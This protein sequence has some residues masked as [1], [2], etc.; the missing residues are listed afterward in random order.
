M[1]RQF[2]KR[3]AEM[4]RNEGDTTFFTVDIGMW[5]IR[6]ILRDFPD[7]ATNVGIYEDGMFGFAAG[8][9]LRGLVPTIFGIQPYLIERTLEQIKLDFAYQKIGV[10][11]VGTGAAV[12]YPKYGYSHYCAEDVGVIK[13]VPGVEFVAPGTAKQFIQLFNQAYRNGHPTFFRVSDHPNTVY[14]FDVEFGKANVIKTGTKATVIAVSVMLDEVME[15][16]ADKD[17]TVLYYTTLEPFDK[18]TLAE[19]CP[20]GNVLICEP[21][22]V[23]SL[24]YDV[25]DALPDRAVKVKHVGF[26]REIFRNYGT[27]DEKMEYYGLTSENIRHILHTLID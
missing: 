25:I 14:D 6:D 11:V 5:A 4:I 9:S 26:P 21:E 16:C 3:V 8:M 7:R 19:N 10:N 23:G 17:V 13:M 2:L 24:L 20:S 18:K 27:Y 15:V 1:R 22:Y 12:D